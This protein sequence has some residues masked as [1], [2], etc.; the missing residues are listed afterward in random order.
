MAYFDDLYDVVDASIEEV[1]ARAALVNYEPKD[2]REPAQAWIPRSL[3]Y[4]P[5]EINLDRV[6]ETI[7]KL[8]IVAWKCRQLDWS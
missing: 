5:D 3:I 7:S 1:T 6:P 8:R 2:G 4:G